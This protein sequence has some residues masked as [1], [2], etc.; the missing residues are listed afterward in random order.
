[1]PSTGAEAQGTCKRLRL[2]ASAFLLLRACGGKRAGIAHAVS[3]GRDP[4]VAALDVCD[5]EL[6][7][8][9]VEGIGDAAQIYRR[10]SSHPK[11]GYLRSGLSDRRRPGESRFRLRAASPDFSNP[12]GRWGS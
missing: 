7:D 3:G 12:E 11:G 4:A 6:V 9:A 10:E 5:V 2:A 8:V 1:M